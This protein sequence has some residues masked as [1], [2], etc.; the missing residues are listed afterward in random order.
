[1]IFKCLCIEAPDPTYLGL[2]AQYQAGFLDADTI[3]RSVRDPDNDL[4]EASVRRS[5]AAKDECFAIR[6]GDRIAAYGWYSRAG[7][8]HV[9][10]TLQLH[11]DPQWVYMYRGFTHPAYRGQRLHAIG[12]T[13]ALAAY[14]E[15]GAK[16]IVSTVE[17][18]NEASL[19]SCAR[20]GYKE[21]GTIYEVRVGKLFGIS[22][23]GHAWLR[24]HLAFRTPGCEAFG[25]WLEAL[26][27]RSGSSERVASVE[28]TFAEPSQER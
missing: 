14:R 13:M 3:W 27:P 7:Y 10:D 18:R 2:G 17:A 12:M 6:E 1:M 26:G 4:D 21:F 5:L 24:R 20:M 22:Q 23:P 9:S 15:R 25:F 16:G 11:F 8:S 19:K 28:A